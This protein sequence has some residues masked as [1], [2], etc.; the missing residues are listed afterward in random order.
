MGLGKIHQIGDVTKYP[1]TIRY[2]CTAKQ[3]A[4]SI[5]TGTTK[6]FAHSFSLVGC[7]SF[8]L[9]PPLFLSEDAFY[10]TE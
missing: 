3:V 5:G 2:I 1:M 9:V 10:S 6:H 8:P 7:P 4:A